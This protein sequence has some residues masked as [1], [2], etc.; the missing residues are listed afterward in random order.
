MGPALGAEHKRRRCTR[1][2]NTTSLQ[3][4]LRI[5]GRRMHWAPTLLQKARGQEGFA[6]R[7][8][9]NARRRMLL[10]YADR[11]C[12]HETEASDGWRL[13]LGCCGWG[14]KITPRDRGPWICGRPYRNHRGRPNRNHVVA[15]TPVGGT[16]LPAGGTR[17]AVGRATRAS[18]MRVTPMR[19]RQ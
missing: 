2:P 14:V 8:Y 18:P 9:P 4:P 6:R 3:T 10:L 19:L 5:A 15:E 11:P 7:Q 13:P 12:A 17:V 1:S 16:L